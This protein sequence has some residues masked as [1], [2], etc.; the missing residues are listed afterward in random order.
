VDGI[1]ADGCLGAVRILSHGLPVENV[2][3]RNI[4]GRYYSRVVCLTKYHG[5]EEERGVIRNVSVTNV[6]ATACEG[7][8]DVRPANPRLFWVQKGVDVENLRL[9][10]IRREEEYSSAPLLL[11]EE[12]ATVTRL[13][14]QDITQKNHTDKPVQFLQIDGKVVDVVSEDVYEV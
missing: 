14:L 3:I 10:H 1:Y 5:G 6:V 8:A 4:F 9:A 7:T 11:I 2:F 12:G 13:R